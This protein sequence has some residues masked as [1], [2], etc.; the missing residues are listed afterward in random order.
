MSSQ[1]KL[2]NFEVTP[3]AEVWHRI[4]NDLADVDDYKTV[5]KKLSGLSVEPPAAVWENIACELNDEV[6]YNKI[7]KKLSG[8]SVNPPVDL[9]HTIEESLNKPETKV[10]PLVP[11]KNRFLKYAVAASVIGL[12]GFFGYSLVESSL[13]DSQHVIGYV[14]KQ[15]TEQTETIHSQQTQPFVKDITQIT[16]AITHLGNVPEKNGTTT[17][18]VVKTPL[19][20]SYSTT[21]E[22]NEDIKG[23]YIVL[24]TNDGN[25][26]RM[27][28]KLST[29][30][31]CIAGEDPNES[32]TAQIEEWQKEL[33]TAPV[34]ST[35][36][37]FL[38]LLEMAN[39]ESAGL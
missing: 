31:D 15:A 36:D 14:N 29:M 25:V 1:H 16:P 28:K 32:C 35:P 9:W 20:N 7:A 13:G 11:S 2:Y 5:S 21:V 33:A 39:K 30:A 12:L 4:A 10:I 26:V 18:A 19:G 34:A 23:R 3:P 37:N 6:A 27:S 38:D 17:T 24:M 8:L 22:K